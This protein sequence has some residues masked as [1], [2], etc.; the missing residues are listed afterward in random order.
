MMRCPVYTALSTH[1]CD[2]FSDAFLFSN[3][4]HSFGTFCYIS[5]SRTMAEDLE[6]EEFVVDKI[7]D[8]RTRNGKIEYYLSWKVCVLS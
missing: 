1:C 7:L 2:I 4:Y 3:I 5:E 6:G 8:K